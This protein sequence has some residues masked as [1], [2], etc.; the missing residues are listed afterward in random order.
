MVK[1]VHNSDLYDSVKNTNQGKY[2][3]SVMTLKTRTQSDC[4]VYRS[5]ISLEGINQYLKFFEGR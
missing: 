4:G 2:G 3:S 1:I 5:S